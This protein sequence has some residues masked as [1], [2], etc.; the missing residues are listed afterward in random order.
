VGEVDLGVVQFIG[1]VRRILRNRYVD[2]PRAVGRHVGWQLRR[3]AHAFPAELP[4]SESVLVASS[5]HCGVSALVNAHGMYDYNNMQLIKRV[6]ADG[7]VLVDVGANVGA[8]SLIASEQPKAQIVAYEPHPATY[9]L[10]RENLRRNG[11]RNVDAICAAVGNR[12]GEIRISDTPGSST[13]HAVSAADAASGPAITVPLLRLDGD[14]ARRGLTPDI[15]KVDVEGFEYDAL[16]GCGVQLGNAALFLVEIN[17]LSDRRSTGG[18][19]ISQLLRDAG[20]DG[21]YYYDAN[22][23]CLRRRVVHIGEDP[24][25]VNRFRA[26]QF[27]ALASL[28]VAD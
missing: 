7:G 20:A 2:R 22:R 24:V 5:G 14:L 26:R 12:D 27:S 16:S 8:F 1:S 17:G 4:L 6:L 25:F 23:R 18:D 11:R 9:E 15:V 3:L 19:R 28:F 21:P 13:T 10:L